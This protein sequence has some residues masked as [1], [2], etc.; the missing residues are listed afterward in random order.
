MNVLVMGGRVVG[1]LVALELVT[2][3]LNA[4]YTGEERHQRRLEKVMAI[5]RRYMGEGIEK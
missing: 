1:E 3:F 5:E 2:A 4:K